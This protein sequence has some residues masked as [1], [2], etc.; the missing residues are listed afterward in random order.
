MSDLRI[1]FVDD[2]ILDVDLCVRT[3]R[4]SSFTVFWKRIE[5]EAALMVCL[6]QDQ[7]DV[8]VCDYKL[9]T[10]SCEEALKLC[11]T[12]RPNIPFM[13]ISG[14]IDEEIAIDLVQKG[15][16]DFIRKH[17]LW[18]LPLAIRREVRNVNEQLRQRLLLEQSFNATITAWG[19]ALE[20]RD[21]NTSGHTLRVTNHAV[22]IA[23]RNNFP[24]ETLK[25]V[26][27]GSLLHDIG[28]IGIPDAILNKKDK[29]SEKE[30]KIMKTH[31]TLAYHFLK[32][33]PFLADAI[34]IPYCHHERY[35]GSGYPQG[36]KGQE[37][38]VCARIFSLA[39]VY[40][41]LTHDRPYRMALKPEHAVK[42]MKEM[43]HWFDPVLFAD[44]M[45]NE[46]D[47]THDQI[48]T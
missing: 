13:V 9:P 6:Q 35:D 44:F 27:L 11:S 8:V 42:V 38:P 48:P 18:R 45:A 21:P 20:L 40:D 37:I 3:L 41:A 15:A 19:S 16:R 29:L 7:W 32:D 2:S 30:W 23:T 26:Y 5:T 36:L 25:N 46:G 14:A 43:E 31:P 12:L 24:G 33:I 17:S 22:V 47:F 28:K 1:L 39:D 10:F 34:A 4:K